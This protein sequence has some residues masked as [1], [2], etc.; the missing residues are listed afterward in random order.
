MTDGVAQVAIEVG[1]VAENPR[2]PVMRFQLATLVRGGLVSRGVAQDTTQVSCW[3]PAK[4]PGLRRST[5]R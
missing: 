5:G 4:A 1:R 2:R 3:R